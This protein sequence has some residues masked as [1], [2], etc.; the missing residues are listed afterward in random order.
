[1]LL[2]KKEAHSSTT[3]MAKPPGSVPVSWGHTAQESHD[4][5]DILHRRNMVPLTYTQENHGY[6]DKQRR[7]TMV[8]LTHTQNNHGSTDIRHRS[9]SYY[10]V[11]RLSFSAK[12]K[13]M[14]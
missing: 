10:I 1:M 6:T 14:G 5:T 7:R 9:H 4:S 3:F 2:G 13:Y 12:N 8:T 11:D